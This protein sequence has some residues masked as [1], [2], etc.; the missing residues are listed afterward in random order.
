MLEPENTH[1]AQSGGLLV[2]M[3]GQSNMLGHARAT[4]G[5]IPRN[6]AVFAWSNEGPDGSWD[7]AAVG[8]APFN[9]KAKSNNA[10]LHFADHL[11]RHHGV[12]VYLVGTPENGSTLLS[13][14]ASDARNMQRLLTEIAFA[15]ETDALREAG[16]RKAD[17][18]IWIQG[19][20]DDERAT[21]VTEPKLSTL[22]AYRTGFCAMVDM[23]VAQPWWSTEETLL[24]A[25]ELVEDGW[26]SARNDFYGNRALW[27]TNC[28]MAV[29]LS[30]G[31]THIGDGAHYDGA[32]LAEI[33]RRMAAV[34]G[35]V[36]PGATDAFEPP[37]TIR[38][39][40]G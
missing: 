14:S 28:R 18:F 38:E 33:G 25:S 17:S 30:A 26:L 22:E 9:P 16:V 39:Q 29:V 36:K 40:R 19:E 13:W 1:P 3:A 35:A 12:P 24:I 27:P 6:R 4:D 21:M 32:A 5:S 31:L 34:R 20:S 7:I 8:R 23:L 15:L 10:G 11:Q 37:E 2:V